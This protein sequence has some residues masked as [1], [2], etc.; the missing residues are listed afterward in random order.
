MKK[1]LKC[2]AFFAWLMIHANGIAFAEEGSPLE[3]GN[4]VIKLIA[5]TNPDFFQ[6][7]G[8]IGVYQEL[9]YILFEESGTAV[10]HS[11]GTVYIIKD[12]KDLNDPDL[13]TAVAYGEVSSYLYAV[14]NFKLF[15]QLH[16]D[17]APQGPKGDQGIQGLEGAAGEIGPAGLPGL[18]GN[19]GSTG[20]VGPVGPVGAAG[21][22]SYS[23]TCGTNTPQDEACKVG[24]VGPGGGWIFFVDKDDDYAGFDYLEAAPADIAAVVWCSNTTTSIPAVAGWDASAVGRGQANTNAMIASSHTAEGSD[25]L[26]GICTTGAA[27]KAYDYVSSNTAATDDWFLGSLGEMM[28]M[29]T[30]LRQAGVGG[31]ANDTYWSSS[32]NFSNFAWYQSFS[33]GGQGNGSKGITYLVRAVRA[34]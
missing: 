25:N 32:E 15:G 13:D 24:S 12:L 14:K 2:L 17:I 28:L 27:V 34:F 23:M 19:R 11:E 3:E 26:T 31:F 29:Y 21:S 16:E 9:N 6:G 7:E 20:P 30:N 18:N 8:K 1:N 5:A 22:F 4:E 10:Y 33:S